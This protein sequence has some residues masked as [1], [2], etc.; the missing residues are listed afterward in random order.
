VQIAGV[1]REK[2]RYFDLT[3]FCGQIRILGGGGSDPGDVA[4]DTTTWQN[5]RGAA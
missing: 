4:V 3:Q 2:S 1:K 5:Q